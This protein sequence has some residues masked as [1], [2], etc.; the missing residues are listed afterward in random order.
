MCV[1]R[2]AQKMSSV[3]EVSTAF[4][5][6]PLGTLLGLGGL[7]AC[8]LGLGTT[9]VARIFVPADTESSLRRSAL[10]L[11]LALC[12]IASV[13]SATAT[14]TWLVVN[15]NNGLPLG[16]ILFSTWML[17]CMVA[18]AAWASHLFI[19]VD[20]GHWRCG[21]ALS[22]GERVVAMLLNPVRTASTAPVVHTE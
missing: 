4:G 22:R 9:L 13:V 21:D 16:N 10:L 12:A 1:H 8:F 17:A 20:A 15:A 11:L 2:Y 5:T 7:I 6:D 3:A 18:A 14:L 19:A